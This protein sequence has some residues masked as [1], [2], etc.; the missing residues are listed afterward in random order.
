MKPIKRPK[1]YTRR[2]KIHGRVVGGR[3]PFEPQK[4]TSADPKAPPVRKA[5][6]TSDGLYNEVA[7]AEYLGLAVRTLQNRRSRGEPPECERHA[8][9]VFYTLEALDRFRNDG[10]E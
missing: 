5:I 8:R 9:R 7:A 3:P 6:I 2:I 4:E 10:D 1:R